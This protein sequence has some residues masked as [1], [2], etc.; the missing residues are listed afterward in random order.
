MI[1]AVSEKNSFQPL[2]LKDVIKADQIIGFEKMNVNDLITP[3]YYYR[4]YTISNPKLLPA[5]L[6]E[7]G[8]IKPIVVN[9]NAERKNIIIDG[10][11]LVKCF[12]KEGIQFIDAILVDLSF[13]QEKKAHYLL[14]ESTSNNSLDMM[15]EFL[16]EFKPEA[17]GLMTPD[18]SNEVLYKKPTLEGK[19]DRQFLALKLGFTKADYDWVKEQLDNIAEEL[20]L[21]DRSVTVIELI[22]HY[23]NSNKLKIKNYENSTR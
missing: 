19:K 3:K 18:K 16:T 20:S 1:K 22:N 12:K 9:I 2:E 21:K 10:N 5:S 14:N 7:F 23:N 15:M 8:Q 17:F 11:N 4:K 13:E 6:A